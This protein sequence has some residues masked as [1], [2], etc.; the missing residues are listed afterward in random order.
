MFFSISE[1]FVIYLPTLK[2]TMK[3]KIEAE[4]KTLYE[5]S[6]E[7]C[8]YLNEEALLDDQSWNIMCE[9]EDK[10]QRNFYRKRLYTF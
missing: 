10:E 8:N 1:L 9:I 3:I 5:Y 4:T 6:E 2:T 7:E